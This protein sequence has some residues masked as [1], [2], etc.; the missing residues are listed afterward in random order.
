MII[1]FSYLLGAYPNRAIYNFSA[2]LIP[3]LI[4]IRF[5]HYKQKGWHYYMIDFCYFGNLLVYLFLIIMPQN[6]I[7]FKVAFL[8]A[9]GPLAHATAAFHNSLIYH[10]IDNLTCLG[11]H[12]VPLA[13]MVNFR[14]VT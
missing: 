12:A 10:K 13:L 2:I 8:F 1:T 9:N 14:W 4:M 11:T 7:M 3:F 5:F 6:Q